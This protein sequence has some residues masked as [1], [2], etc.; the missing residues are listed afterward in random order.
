M[1]NVR[2]SEGIQ[3]QY[4][5]LDHAKDYVA[6]RSPLTDI[7]NELDPTY[8]DQLTR[9]LTQ[10]SFGIKRINHEYKRAV[11]DG[12]SNR[13]AL[14]RGTRQLL[15]VFRARFG[16]PISTHENTPH[17]EIGFQRGARLENVKL[18]ATPENRVEVFN[19]LWGPGQPRGRTFDPMYCRYEQQ[20]LVDFLHRIGWLK[21]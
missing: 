11:R 17:W 13:K 1:T 6:T 19:D 2:F 21:S 7:M 15:H 20:R 4:K 16:D 10:Q 14:F 3:S 9:P 18:R 5:A 12:L 8:L